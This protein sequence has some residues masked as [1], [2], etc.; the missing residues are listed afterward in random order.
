[1]IMCLAMYSPV[2][3]DLAPMILMARLMCRFNHSYTSQSLIGG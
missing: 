2:W 3:G 1:M